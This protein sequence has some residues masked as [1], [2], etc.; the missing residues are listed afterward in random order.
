MKKYL[1]FLTLLVGLGG[2]INC[3]SGPAP[4]IYKHTDLAM[5][6]IIEITI[7]DTNERHANQAIDAAMAEIKRIGSLFYE[8]NPESPLY[9][10]SHRTTD[11][12]T[13]PAEVL[14]LIERGLE[15]S[16]ITDGCFDMTVGILLPYWD[17]KT[18]NPMPP[19]I[20]DIKPVLPFVDYH[21]LKVDYG[22][23]VLISASPK[24]MLATGAIAKGYA[25]DRAIA[26]LLKMGVKGAL[27][28]AGGDLRV[29][30]RADGK[31]WRVGIQNPREPG[32]LLQVIEVDSGAVVTSGDYQ[33]YFIYN[34]KRYHHLLNPKTG[35]PADSCRSVT[36][37][38]ATA[39]RA[40][41][42]ATGI[43]V[44]GAQRGI[45]LIESLPNTEGL[46]VKSD[47]KVV[48][49]SGF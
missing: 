31:S 8:G 26:V 25:V 13:M 47:G 48:K 28:N 10:F 41:A 44:M 46:I 33:K 36:I 49:S 23:S 11:R 39:E 4:K 15:I 20:S 34:G 18:D 29:T 9:K 40:D 14:N 37:K 16:K 35:F 21:S 22:D 19:R 6:T 17:F 30:P 12:T 32:K 45:R 7:L 24:T 3:K 38:T 43:F 27:V 2:L 5:G 42:L 1:M